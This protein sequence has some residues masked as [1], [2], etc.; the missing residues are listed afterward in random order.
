[1]TLA[2]PKEGYPIC[3]AQNTSHM[4]ELSITVRTVAHAVSIP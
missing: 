4:H 2:A 1:M 3:A